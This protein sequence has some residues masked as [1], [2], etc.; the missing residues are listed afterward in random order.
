MP[1]SK[2]RFSFY[3]L[4][5]MH[6]PSLQTLVARVVVVVIVMLISRS[7]CYERNEFRPVLFI[8]THKTGGSTIG[9]IFRNI[10]DTH[11]WVN[12]TFLP[13]ERNNGG[14]WNFA[15]KGDQELVAKNYQHKTLRYWV[16]HIIWNDDAAAFLTPFFLEEPVL[17]T[18]VREPV[19]WLRSALMYFYRVEITKFVAENMAQNRN[20]SAANLESPMLSHF[21]PPKRLFS[22]DILTLVLE[23]WDVS[24]V[25]L[26][27]RAGLPCSAL[28]MHK[29]KDQAQLYNQQNLPPL[30]VPQKRWLDEQLYFEKQMYE[31]ALVRLYRFY[32]TIPHLFRVQCHQGLLDAPESH[33][34]D[35]VEWNRER[36]QTI[37]QDEG[38]QKGEI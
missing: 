19:D 10:A 27:Y 11:N 28:R 17:V 38:K 23:A 29:L 35:A 33:I 14:T 37:A 1:K 22:D 30:S 16:N 25:S 9:S 31:E 18:I 4:P 3:W 8:K 13:C 36:C 34:L 12:E 2:Y 15:R 20:L 24:L 7:G 5:V 21:E 32:Q 6:V 26:A